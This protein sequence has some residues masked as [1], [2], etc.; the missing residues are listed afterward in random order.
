[1]NEEKLN[2][3]TREEAIY[4]LDNQMDYTYQLQQENNFLKADNIHVRKIRDNLLNEYNDLQEE[5]R[6]LLE[7]SKAYKKLLKTTMQKEHKAIKVLDEIR[8]YVIKHRQIYDIDGSIEKQ[9]DE[10]NILASPKKIL[11]ILDKVKE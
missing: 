4:Y 11:Q 6:Q 5:N 9:I 3:L 1:M 7:T 10:F 8:E 2:S